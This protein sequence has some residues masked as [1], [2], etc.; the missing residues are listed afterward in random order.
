M[1]QRGIFQGDA[2]S[3]LLFIIAMIHITTYSENAQTD[4]NIA[5]RKRRSITWFTL[6]KL[7]FF[8][9]NENEMETLKH[10]VKIYWLDIME[11][12]I[13]KCA[14]LV[15]KS[16]KWPMTE[17]MELLNPEKIRTLGENETYK[18]LDILE[19]DTIKL[20]EMKDKI[21][22]EH[23]RRTRKLP[24]IELSSRKLIKGINTW[25]VLFVRYSGPFFKW[26]RD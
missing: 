18:Y 4:T 5:D 11:F 6:M 7:N 12:G 21:Q 26:T 25:A 24:E 19:A 16:G 22:K 2:L 13:E 10:T 15:M 14:M 3:P 9:K 20:V 23:I 1:I 17:G 8:A